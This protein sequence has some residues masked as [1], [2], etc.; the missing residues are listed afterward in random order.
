MPGTK[1]RGRGMGGRAGVDVHEDCD[2]DDA[3]ENDLRRS[4][5]GETLISYEFAESLSSR[6]ARRR[7][8]PPSSPPAGG[9]CRRN[10][11][12]FASRCIHINAR[13][14]EGEVIPNTAVAGFIGLVGRRRAGIKG[15]NELTA[16]FREF[17]ISPERFT[18][19]FLDSWLSGGASF[20][21][22]FR[23]GRLS[24]ILFCCS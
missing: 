22:I 18:P 11:K 19:R 20:L 3:E 12:V 2:G 17:V 14:G 1:W 7:A 24:G 21:L 8:E 15:S 16:R 23:R 6:A 10:R 4:F 9:K 13:R 5:R